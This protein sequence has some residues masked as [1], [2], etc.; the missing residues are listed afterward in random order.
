[1]R[2]NVP[3]WEVNRE[4]TQ[5]LNLQESIASERPGRIPSFEEEKKESSG[6]SN[7]ELDVMELLSDDGVEETS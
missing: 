3:V 4:P 5:A 2:A 1:M 6:S 7:T